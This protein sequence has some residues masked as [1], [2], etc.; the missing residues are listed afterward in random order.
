MSFINA[1]ADAIPD[2][3]FRPNKQSNTF[4]N[5]ATLVFQLI[6]LLKLGVLI[7]QIHTFKPRLITLLMLQ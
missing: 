4:L 1:S 2:G 7:N 5:L 6:A 3:N